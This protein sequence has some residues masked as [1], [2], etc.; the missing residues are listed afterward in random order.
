MS[1]LFKSE[2]G[3]SEIIGE[4][5]MLG[6]T[7]AIIGI[8]AVVLYSQL[9]VSAR[10]PIVAMD[11]STADGTTIVLRHDGGDPVSFDRLAF[12]V[13]GMR[14]TTASPSVQVGDTN[15]NGVWEPGEAIVLAMPA[16]TASQ[17]VY[18]SDTSSL[19]DKFT[20]GM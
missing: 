12:V 9:T 3:V 16:E 2:Y 8:V 6:I 7:V 14:L 17:A 15:H 10:E 5:L 4:M 18:D 1:R 11:A 20:I 13:G 19:M